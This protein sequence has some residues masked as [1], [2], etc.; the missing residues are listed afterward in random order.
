MQ[1]NLCSWYN[2][3]VIQ[4]EYSL[5]VGMTNDDEWQ[6][7]PHVLHGFLD[8]ELERLRANDVMDDFDEDPTTNWI[9]AVDEYLLWCYDVVLKMPYTQEDA[10]N[11]H[12]K[13]RAMQLRVMDAFPRAHGVRGWIFNKW[14]SCC[15]HLDP[16]LDLGCT[17]NA[18]NST[19]EL[20]HKVCTNVK[21]ANTNRKRNW[22]NQLMKNVIMASELFAIANQIQGEIAHDITAV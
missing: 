11:F 17:Q 10:D 22:E 15:H 9:A 16:I 7:M 2:I 8:D 5:T 21:A 20:L 18:C 4:G 14:H 19:G 1:W 13:T 12:A 3:N 6:A